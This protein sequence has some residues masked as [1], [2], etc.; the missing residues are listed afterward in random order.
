MYI[1]CIVYTLKYVDCHLA[2]IVPIVIMHQM[3][4]DY[5]IMIP[6]ECVAQLESF[7]AEV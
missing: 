3:E 4:A 6:T 2:S 7:V 1:Q 5:N